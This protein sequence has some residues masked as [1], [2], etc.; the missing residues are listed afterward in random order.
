M[1]KVVLI[2]VLSVLT[3]F[4]VSLFAQNNCLIFDGSN[5]YVDCGSGASLNVTDNTISIEAW[6]YPTNFK[7]NFWNNTIVGNDNWLNPNTEGY[8]FRFG[9]PNGDLDFTFS[10]T[11][12]QNWASVTAY[13]ALVLNTWQHVAVAYNGVTAKLYV[14]GEE[15][16]SNNLSYN[17]Y[18]ST[19]PLNIGRST[20][21]IADRMFVGMMDEVRIWE[22]ART[23][24]EIL[25]NMN[26]ELTGSEE[27][28]VAYYMFN[29]GAGQI[30][31]DA[32]GNNDGVLGTISDADSADP[33]WS[34]SDLI[35]P[36]TLSS[37][38]AAFIQDSE[39]V[40]INWITQTEVNC[41]GWNI[42]RSSQDEQLMKLNSEIITGAGSSSEP[43]EYTYLD[44]WE[45]VENTTYEYWL[46]NIDFSSTTVMYGPITA[47]IQMNDDEDETPE[48]SA[49]YG[50]FQNYPNPF[51]PS[52]TISFSLQ[53]DSVV[54]LVIYDFRGKKVTTLLKNR[55][56]SK[57]KVNTFTWN[58]CNDNG[59][60]VGT[61][62]YFYKLK[63]DSFETT[64]KMLLLK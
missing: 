5:D 8:V 18:S 53:E 11:G 4:A 58:G 29:E 10:Y 32:T 2:F 6:I 12:G 35:L 20:G 46:E 62:L 1:K 15:K 42:Y 40:S 25:N 44:S 13:S 47:T 33:V 14:N 60:T 34:S 57:D 36:I 41:M 21:S 49:N 24:T 3:I 27:G 56:I 48:V 28:L 26:R 51:N 63:T 7:T 43:T 54:E 37:F 45:L 9:G 38:T 17:I 52:T 19:K 61:G 16:A 39:L 22:D 30:A 55:S 23:E 31:Y 64:K 59:E 50:L